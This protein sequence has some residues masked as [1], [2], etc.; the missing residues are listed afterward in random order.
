MQ[1]QGVQ[2]QTQKP[3]DGKNFPKR[4]QSVT[5][6]YTGKLMNGKQFDSS[7]G[8]QP[9]TFKIGMGQVIKGW[10][11]GVA[12]MSLGETAILKISPEYGYGARGAGASIPPNSVLLFQVE[13]L[14]IN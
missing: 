9:F 11:E 14:G 7:V 13:L 1:N 10:D 3:G 4:G 8:K 12:K 2:K 6:H 5:V